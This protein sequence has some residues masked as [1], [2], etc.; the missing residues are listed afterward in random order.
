MYSYFSLKHYNIKFK[1]LKDSLNTSVPVHSAHIW[2]HLHL[3]FPFKW[4]V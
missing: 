4:S 1:Y 3:T 2:Q